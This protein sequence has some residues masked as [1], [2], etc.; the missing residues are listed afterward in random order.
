M[1]QL[2]LLKKDNLAFTIS[3]SQKYMQKYMEKDFENMC[4][5]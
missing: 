2:K 1:R 3:I 5:K 4:I